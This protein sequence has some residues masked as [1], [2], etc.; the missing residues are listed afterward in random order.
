MA[1]GESGRARTAGIEL[2]YRSWG[3]AGAPPA[4]LLHALGEQSSDW[5]QVAAALA[6]AYR[7]YAPD[8]RG[9]GASD[10]PG[11]Y[12][13]E[14]LVTDLE[15]FIGAL[16]LDQVTLVGH[17]V[18]APS[19]YLYAARHPDRVVRLVLEE[20][21]PPWP[22]APRAASRPAGPLPFDWDV[23]AL[24][25]QLTEPS[26]SSW[27]DELTHVRAPAL[28]VAGGPDSHVDQ[29]QLADL[30]GLIPDCEL[31]TIPA[32]HL[33]HAARAAE[34]NAAVTAFLRRPPGGVGLTPG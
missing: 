17:S 32:G 9:H 27:R 30:A 34:F 15:G 1:D 33:V 24:S 26:V 5:A 12:T 14:Q 21:A 28:I 2:A 20:P 8:L 11:G 7:V 25:N 31:I 19:A 16:G 13:F 23:T 10:W 3:P 6:P 22:R 18:G 29:G 4:V